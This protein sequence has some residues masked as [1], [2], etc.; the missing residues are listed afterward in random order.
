M[1][2]GTLKSLNDKVLPHAPKKNHIKTFQNTRG[3]EK[4]LSKCFQRE[5][6]GY[7]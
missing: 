5:K 1:A 2:K 4:I 7:I 3:K 6:K